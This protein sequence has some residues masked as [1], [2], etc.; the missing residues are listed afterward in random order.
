MISPT[1]SDVPRPLGRSHQRT[2]ARN[3]FTLVEVLLVVAIILVLSAVAVPAL[4]KSVRG[5]RLR[6]AAATVVQAG[7]YARSMAILTQQE[8][9][10]SFDVRSSTLRVS[11]LGRGAGSPTP[12]PEPA[13]GPS[14]ALPQD[15]ASVPSDSGT[16]ALPPSSP[17]LHLT[18]VLDE[19]TVESVTLDRMGSETGGSVAVLYR[20]NGRCTP[21]RVRL[22]DDK[23][24]AIVVDVDA[25]SSAEVTRAPR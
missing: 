4:S 15:P 23:G 7:R 20:T 3:G 2:T 22:V 5:N 13:P 1:D 6:V 17:S 21:Y 24:G 12:V 19:V 8:M 16:P 18:K 14:P 25:L 10:L 11:P 9:S